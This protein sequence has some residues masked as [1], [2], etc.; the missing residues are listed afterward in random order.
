MIVTPFDRA[1][2]VTSAMSKSGY[3]CVKLKSQPQPNQPLSPTSSQPLFQPSI[4]PPPKPFLAAKSMY[5]LA[6]A[7]VAP[8]FGPEF[9]VALSRC[10][11][12]QMPTYFIGFTQLT[13]PSWLGSLRFRI[14]CAD[15]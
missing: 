5:R 1:Y 2:R 4:K 3:A 6:F 8:C 7:V 15:L 13:S 14:I 10:I 12:H 9:H 11:A